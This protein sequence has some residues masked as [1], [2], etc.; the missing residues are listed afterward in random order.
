MG[1]QEPVPW[2]MLLAS[3]LP[4]LTPCC[5]EDTTDMASTMLLEL[6]LL[7]VQYPWLLVDTALRPARVAQ[8]TPCRALFPHLPYSRPS[9]PAERASPPALEPLSSS[10]VERFEDCFSTIII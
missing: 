6:S 5:I 8:C 1:A 10:T 2:S 9:L 4:R 3:V 7:E